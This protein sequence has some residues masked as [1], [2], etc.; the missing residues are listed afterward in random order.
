M[1]TYSSEVASWIHAAKFV[2]EVYIA[3]C[4]RR[5]SHKFDTSRVKEELRRSHLGSRLQWP[6]PNA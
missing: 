2:L 3:R 4:L 6:I 5:R 1:V